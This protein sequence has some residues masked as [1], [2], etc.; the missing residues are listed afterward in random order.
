M[1]GQLLTTHDKVYYF[2]PVLG[3]FVI[4]PTICV[5]LLTLTLLTLKGQMTSLRIFTW[6]ILVTTIFAG[7]LS[8]FSVDAFFFLY[9]S[10]FLSV[11]LV[12]PCL[13][14][15]AN[16]IVPYRWIK[17]IWIRLIGLGFISTIVTL[18]IF[19]MAM[20]FSLV[21]N[22]TDP[23]PKQEQHIQRTGDYNGKHIAKS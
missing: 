10:N 21:S 11:L 23:G 17:N 7:L 4:F 15:L 9:C 6:S 20:F 3:T 16:R 2:W 19:G 22:P 5:F 13:T 14:F 18:I 8:W 12:I 1:N